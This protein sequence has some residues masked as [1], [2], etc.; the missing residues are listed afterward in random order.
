MSSASPVPSSPPSPLSS[1]FSQCCSVDSDSTSENPADL[2]L[3]TAACTPQTSETC[4]I[5]PKTRLIVFP[6]SPPKLSKGRYVAS[7]GSQG[8]YECLAEEERD[9]ALELFTSLQRLEDTLESRI[10]SV[11][12]RDLGK[13]NREICISLPIASGLLRRRINDIKS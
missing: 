10:E 8:V 13:R 7:S 5:F 3:A 4:L 6:T 1:S 12:V 11:C 9:C 2:Q